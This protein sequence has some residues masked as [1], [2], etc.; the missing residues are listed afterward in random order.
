M[1]MAYRILT[2]RCNQK[3]LCVAECRLQ[4]IRRD[5][6]NRLVIDP[7]LCTDCGSCAD[8]CPLGAIMGVVTT[9]EDW[10]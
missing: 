3:G 5:A 10:F 8:F 7:D 9:S 4:A 6:E 2:D 1:V